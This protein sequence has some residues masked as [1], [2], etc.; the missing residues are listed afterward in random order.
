MLATVAKGV[1]FASPA[2]PAS[3]VPSALPMAV[4]APVMTAKS[5]AAAEGT[6]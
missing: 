1:V 2:M 4:T 5:P 3:P 6:E